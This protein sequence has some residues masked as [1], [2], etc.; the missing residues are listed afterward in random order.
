V[1]YL[2]L[3]AA[4]WV[5][6]L[7]VGAVLFWGIT[8][9]PWTGL[10]GHVSNWVI[11]FD[12]VAR[13]YAVSQSFCGECADEYLFTVQIIGA[14]LAFYFGTLAFWTISVRRLGRAKSS[15]GSSDQ[16]RS[17]V[18]IRLLGLSV[19]FAATIWSLLFWPD[20]ARPSAISPSSSIYSMYGFSLIFMVS[21]AF[22]VLVTLIMACCV[23][24]GHRYGW[25]K[26][27]STG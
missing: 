27:G 5:L 21:T 2:V 24:W 12:P 6:S 25:I 19:V 10:I 22:H 18:T 14:L 3:V 13:R 15:A 16:T 26:T 23:I 8:M 4:T 9:S 7:V 17:K 20:L 1:P 11:Q